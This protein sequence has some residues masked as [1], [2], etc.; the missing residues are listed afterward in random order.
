LISEV[1]L[2]KKSFIG[3]TSWRFLNWAKEEQIYCTEGVL[4]PLISD[5]FT[6]AWEKFLQLLNNSRG[7]GGCGFEGGKLCFV[8]KRLKVNQAKLVILGGSVCAAGGEEGG[9]F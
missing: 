1:S 4:C 7:K 3:R 8:G 6:G 9:S 2:V 5:L